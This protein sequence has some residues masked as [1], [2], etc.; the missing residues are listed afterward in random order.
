MP[1]IPVGA[2]A[3]ETTFTVFVIPVLKVVVQEISLTRTQYEVVAVGETVIAL[4]VWFEI[5]LLPTAPVPH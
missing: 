2:V 5:M 1:E 4:P 3:F